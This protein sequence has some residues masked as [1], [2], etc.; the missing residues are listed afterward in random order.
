MQHDSNAEHPHFEEDD[1]VIVS[2]IVQ[3]DSWSWTFE[4]SF[5]QLPK[6]ENA[7]IINVVEVKIILIERD[8]CVEAIVQGIEIDVECVVICL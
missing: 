4:P 7:A 3:D 6:I 8:W 1:R 5:L 2:N